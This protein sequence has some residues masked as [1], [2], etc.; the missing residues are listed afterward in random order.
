VTFY[1]GG[2]FINIPPGMDHS[3]L[4]PFL[5]AS[6]ARFLV[7]DLRTID[8]C[9]KGFTGHTADL[10]IDRVDLSEFRNYKEYSFAVYRI[11]E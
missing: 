3:A 7:V 11:R 4:G 2:E 10:R 6:G 8:E 5:R 9:V 1:K